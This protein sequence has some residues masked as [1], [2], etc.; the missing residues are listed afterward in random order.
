MLCTLIPIGVAFNFLVETS[1]LLAGTQ[2][3]GLENRTI[4]IIY[5]STYIN[6]YSFLILC[7][8]SPPPTS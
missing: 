7:T 4:Y 8:W 6:I 3:A 1:F 2:L 5:Y